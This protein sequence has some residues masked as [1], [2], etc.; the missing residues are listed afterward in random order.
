MPI[1]YLR[2]LWKE[3]WK[4]TYFIKREIRLKALKRKF[5][6]NVMQKTLKE[7]QKRNIDLSNLN[8]L[9]VFAGKGD[10]LT[11]DFNRAVRSLEAWEINPD[12]KKY[13]RFNLPNAKIKITDSYKEIMNIIKKDFIVI[14]NHIYSPDSSHIEHFDIFPHIFK[15]T[16]D[17]AIIIMNVLPCPSKSDLTLYPHWFGDI[18][19]NARKKFYQTEDPYHIDE[20]QMITVYS[21]LA[22]QENYKI[23]WYFFKKR[24]SIKFLVLKINKQ[25]MA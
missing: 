4:Y 14:D 15:I 13:L 7:I 16:N 6:L 1:D 8:A 24:N 25:P 21:K 19:I 9:D 5:R 22:Q 11:L 23:D 18:H 2:N 10:W 20:Q 3:K 12:F 17:E